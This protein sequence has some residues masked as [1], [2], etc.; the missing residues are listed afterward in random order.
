[1]GG[2]KTTFVKSYVKALGSLDHVSSPTFT[3][4]KEYT[5]SNMKIL[6]YDFYRLDNPGLV[7]DMLEESLDDSKTVSL[8]EWGGSVKG[9]LP[10]NRLVI[11]IVKD[12]QNDQ[13]R[14][15]TFTC[16]KET[17]YLLQGLYTC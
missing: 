16:P 15:F 10:K 7:A 12:A 3:V 13:G 9:V 2:G 4:S 6:H 8:I 11:T 14:V 1:L 17:E 5:A